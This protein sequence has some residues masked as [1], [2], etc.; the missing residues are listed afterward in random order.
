MQYPEILAPAG[1]MAQL[2]AAAAAGCDAVYLGAKAFNAR[3]GADN[4]ES[5]KDAVSYCHARGIKVYVTFNTLLQEA[6]LPRAAKTLQEIAESGADGMLATDLGTVLMWKACCPQLPIHAST[7]MTVHSPTG[8]KLLSGLGFTRAV[9]A[10]EMT[11]EEIQSVVNAVPEME[12]E[13]FVHG[14]LCMSVSGQCYLSSILGGRSGNR[15]QCAQPCRLD[16]SCEGR[17]YALSLKD[18]TLIDRAREIAELGV[19]SLKIEGRLKRPEYAAAA[20]LELRKALRGEQIDL[21]LLEDVFSR[22]GFTSGYYDGRR[23]ARMFGR[24]TAEDAANEKDAVARVRSAIR[25]PAAHVSAT[26]T[27]AV[28]RGENAVLTMESSG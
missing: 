7:Q 15:G 17:H 1:G 10:R 16:F 2:E 26:L 28:R 9:L 3:M 27:F 4:F 11:R 14:A 5:L 22:S 25:V 6:E 19:T 20:V 23:D 8:A 12:T 18:L 21:S 13:I 24:R